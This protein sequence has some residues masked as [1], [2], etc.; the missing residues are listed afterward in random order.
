MLRIPT[1]MLETAGH[2]FTK[3][4]LLRIYYYFQLLARQF[5]N[6]SHCLDKVTNQLTAPDQRLYGEIRIPH[7]GFLKQTKLSQ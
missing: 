7:K 5:Y 3:C 6:Q 1:A 4:V 2:K